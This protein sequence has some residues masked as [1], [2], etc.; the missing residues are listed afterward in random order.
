MPFG[1]VKKTKGPIDSLKKTYFWPRRLIAL[2]T[3]SLLFTFSIGGMSST[4]QAFKLVWPT[5]NPAFH[6]GYLL[7][8]Y[9]Q[10]T[11]SGRIASGLFGCQR[12]DGKR[13][14]EGIDLK[15]IYHDRY[16]DAEDAVFAVMAGKVAYINKTA[17]N[18]SYGRY[19][20]LIHDSVQP[21]V[22]TLYAHLSH[23]AQG[24]RED[25]RIE[26]GT[27]IGTIGHS[28]AGYIIPKQ[29]AHLHFEIGLRLSDDFQKWYDRQGFG[30][31]NLHGFWNGMNLVGIDPLHFYEAM[32]NDPRLTLDN[33]FRE[34]PVAMTLQIATHRIPDFIRRYPTLLTGA[35]P[36]AEIHGWEIAFTGFG[37]PKS[38]RPLSAAEQPISTREN[39]M[40]LINRDKEHIETYACCDA[41]DFKGEQV[42]PGK[43]LRQ[44]LDIL[45]GGK[46]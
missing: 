8:T 22:Y 38:W 17:G 45:F 30:T 2:S 6:K 21:T 20:V 4:A 26:A 13:F 25:L 34:L 33:Y 44:R 42:L 11:G 37:L 29:R 14:H 39:E 23:I 46:L 7:E 19:I 43:Q 5:P 32:S 28:A 31:P 24:I 36:H 16:G 40:V 41:I 1:K 12:N 10:P 3:I 27:V 15:A 9:I 18:S 35:L